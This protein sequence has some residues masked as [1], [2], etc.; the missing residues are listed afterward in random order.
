LGHTSYVIE[1]LVL[2]FFIAQSEIV[3]LCRF[4]M[5]AKVHSH[6]MVIAIKF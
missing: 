1:S 2:L 6:Y 4:D 3:K 5:S